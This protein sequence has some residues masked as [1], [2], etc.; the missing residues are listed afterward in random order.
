MF[1]ECGICFP[2]LVLEWRLF[3]VL[4]QFWLFFQILLHKN[5]NYTIL[6]YSSLQLTSY[7]SYRSLLKFTNCIVR[8]LTT[9]HYLEACGHEMLLWCCYITEETLRCKNKVAKIITAWKVSIYGVISGPYFPVFGLN[10]EIY[11]VFGHFSR[12]EINP[13]ISHTA[14]N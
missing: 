14:K 12:A 8:H 5:I 9:P 11:S 2:N 6:S 1:N 7:T 4:N 13:V 3:K 10:T